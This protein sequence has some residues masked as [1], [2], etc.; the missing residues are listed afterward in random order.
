MKNCTGIL[1]LTVTVCFL[2]LSGLF[3]GGLQGEEKAAR[4]RVYELRTYVTHEGKLPD[5]NKRFRDHTMRLFEKHG[6]KNVVY[7][8]PE[9]TENT[10]VYLIS[11]ES[12]EAAD[13][14]WAAFQKDPEW[15][16][17]RDESEKNGKILVRVDRQYL[18]P[19]DY[20]PMK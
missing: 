15:H 3:R 13:A 2:G 11:H 10:L 16:K 20:S 12:R 8:L 1:C 5:L 6:I 14:S 9:K 17:V 4:E 18:L 19:T 7:L